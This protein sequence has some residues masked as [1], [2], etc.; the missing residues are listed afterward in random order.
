MGS[1]T[2]SG[3]WNNAYHVMYAF[4][5]GNKNYL[6]AHNI[7]TLYWFVQELLPGGKMG[8][9]TD[10]GHWATRYAAQ[11]PFN[12]G[13]TQYIYG[14]D[15]GNPWA[16]HHKIPSQGELAAGL[17]L[18]VMM[19]PLM[20]PLILGAG[21]PTVHEPTRRWFIQKVLPGGKMGDEIDSGKWIG[22]YTTQFPFAING[23][24]YF[25]GQDLGVGKWII[26]GLD[27]NGKIGN[28]LQNGKWNDAREVQVPFVVGGKQYFYGRDLSS[29]AWYI[30]QIN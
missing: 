19:A 24:Q 21:P 8:S 7:A 17:A 4:S 26:Q 29:R 18:N 23:K 11:F 6:F 30:Q 2:D 22:I 15:V 14:Q 10:Q 1:Q 13:D 25:Y 5:V 27:A 20:F 9:E 16:R 3:H 12:V 28:E